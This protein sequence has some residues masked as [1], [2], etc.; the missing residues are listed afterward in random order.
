MKRKDSP[1]VFDHEAAAN[2]PE[3]VTRKMLLGGKYATVST[4]KL[5]PGEKRVDPIKELLQIREEIVREEAERVA[6]EATKATSKSARNKA[7]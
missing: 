2:M 5:A 7:A 1:T 4:L 6:R 3:T